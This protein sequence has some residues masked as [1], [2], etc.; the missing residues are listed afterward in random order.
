MTTHCCC[1]C[2]F[3]V[4]CHR[5][6]THPHPRHFYH[7]N[8]SR[9]P[10]FSGF[11]FHTATLSVLRV[12]FQVQLSSVVNLMTVFLLR[13]PKLYSNLSLL[14]RCLQLLP[15]RSYISCSTVVVSLHIN[16]CNLVPFMLHL[17]VTFLFAGIAT[18]ISMHVSS[19]LF[20]FILCVSCLL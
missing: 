4:S 11:Q 6:P 13:P 5:P 14:V 15:V 7:L 2:Y 3:A 20:L 18:S 17:C 9:S 12:M 16:S 10:P 19:F 1:C 8:Q